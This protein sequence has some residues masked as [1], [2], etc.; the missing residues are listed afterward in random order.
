MRISDWSS[1]VC[2]SDLAVERVVARA[3]TGGGPN[4]RFFRSPSPL[5]KT[6]FKDLVPSRT[7]RMGMASI[8]ADIDGYTAFVDNAIAKGAGAMATAATGIHVIREELNA[9]LK[10][11]CGGKRDR[12]S[13]RMNASH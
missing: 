5:A 7:L 8:F 10:E 6:K 1:D 4:F 13:T 2:S 11:D 9:V 3:S 12:K